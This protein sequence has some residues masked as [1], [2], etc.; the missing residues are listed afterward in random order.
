VKTPAQAASNLPPP[1]PTSYKDD[2]KS[3]TDW[4]APNI[5]ASN[6]SADDRKW[7]IALHRKRVE[8][9]ACGTR[10][11]VRLHCLPLSPD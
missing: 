10:L 11:G 7:N 8:G 9:T 4:V 2:S 5:W 3:R 6:N 1:P